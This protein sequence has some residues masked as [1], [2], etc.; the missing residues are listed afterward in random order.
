MISYVCLAANFSYIPGLISTTL[1]ALLNVASRMPEQMFRFV[2]AV[3]G[4]GKFC[5]AWAAKAT[6]ME[7]PF[8]PSASSNQS[9]VE[10]ST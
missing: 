9:A 1:V 7:N 2:S 6:A 3:V 8:R 4:M 5:T 10:R